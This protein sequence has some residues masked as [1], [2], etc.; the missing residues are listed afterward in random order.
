MVHLIFKLNNKADYSI[1]VWG[2]TLDIW[3]EKKHGYKPH[4]THFWKDPGFNPADVK[5]GQAEDFGNCWENNPSIY[6]RKPALW[7]KDSKGR[8]KMYLEYGW[9]TLTNREAEMIGADGRGITGTPIHPWDQQFVIKLR[10]I[11]DW[12][13]AEVEE[14]NTWFSAYLEFNDY[15]W[16]PEETYT[17]E[18]LRAWQDNVD[19]SSKT[20]FL[21]MV[22]AGGAPCRKI[23]RICKIGM[24]E[25]EYGHNPAPL[26][27]SSYKCCEEC[28][29]TFVMPF[30]MNMLNDV[31]D[32]VI[33][34]EE[35]NPFKYPRTKKLSLGGEKVRIGFK[36][37]AG[38]MG[39]T[40]SDK[41]QRKWCDEERHTLVAQQ[42]LLT[43]YLKMT[44]QGQPNLGSVS[45]SEVEAKM[46]RAEEVIEKANEIQM[47]V[48][49]AKDEVKLI[50]KA[51]EQ[52]KAEIRQKASEARKTL[53][54]VK[55]A[56]APKDKQIEKL[57]TEIVKRDERIAELKVVE[58]V[59]KSLDGEQRALIC[60]QQIAK[61]IG[62]CEVVDDFTDEPRGIPDWALDDFRQASQAK[63][64]AEVKAAA[65]AKKKAKKKTIPTTPCQYCDKQCRANQLQN[66][67]GDMLCGSCA[68]KAGQ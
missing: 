19:Y 34:K 42:E 67:W 51:N 1:Q 60:S 41:T 11:T 18:D 63:M 24:S 46:K 17:A 28:N 33:P 13:D 43:K 14:L 15:L 53:E 65:E 12:T 9:E 35:H 22:E 68:R 39:N 16:R 23:C 66:V 36:T 55:R 3:M 45:G 32:C 27:S 58:G 59:I 38:C 26:Y 6:P 21:A 49:E 29:G 54:R 57:K 62:R 47:M 61:K 25:G 2:K 30:R 8:G 52:E 31:A 44:I 20:T 10:H 56:Q 7:E 50:E 48:K 4:N 64:M 37:Q 5:S 40:C